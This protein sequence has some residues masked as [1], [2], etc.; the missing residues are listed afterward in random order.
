[1]PNQNNSQDNIRINHEQVVEMIKAIVSGNYSLACLL[2]L[3]YGGYDPS[4]YIPSN[5]YYRLIRRRRQPKNV[6]KIQSNHLDSEK[7]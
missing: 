3:E 4:H 7:K 5:T 2:F 1:M 6:K